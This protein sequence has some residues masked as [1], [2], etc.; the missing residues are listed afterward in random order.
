MFC[1]N[2]STKVDNNLLNKQLCRCCLATNIELKPIFHSDGSISEAIFLFTGVKIEESDNFPKTICTTCIDCLHKC[3]SFKQNVESSDDWL[4]N[5]VAKFKFCVNPDFQ[6]PY[7]I[8]ED[9]NYTTLREKHDQSSSCSSKSLC[10]KNST[11][12]KD[13]LKSVLTCS[14]CEA[15]FSF[16]EDFFIHT[17]LHD[18]SNGFI[19]K[20]CNKSFSTFFKLKRHIPTH[21]KEKPFKCQ[22]CDMRFIEMA[23]LT[24]HFRVHTGEKQQSMYFCEV[25]SKGFPNLYTLKVHNRIHTGERP[26]KCDDC[27]KRFSDYRLLNSHK[28]LHDDNKPYQC[29]DCN[30]NFRHR[31]TLVTHM[32]IH[33][34]N[35]GNRPHR[36][37]K[38]KKAFKQSWRLQIHKRYKH[39]P[40]NPKKRRFFCDQCCQIFNAST[41]LEDHLQWH[42]KNVE[43]N[44]EH[45]E[46]KETP[47]E[48]FFQCN[49]CSL[50]FSSRLDLITHQKLKHIHS[51]ECF[52]CFG[53]WKTFE[54]LIRHKCAEVLK[55]LE[56]PQADE[57]I[58]LPDGQIQDCN[59]IVNA[60][61]ASV[62]QRSGTTPAAENEKDTTKNSS[63]G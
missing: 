33:T 43:T 14:I 4:K 60:L 53:K 36:C 39:N 9:H 47:S 51:H 42:S 10:L 35:I 40:D 32:K 61:L 37:D 20:S 7:D 41:A 58:L 3:I 56:E 22:L 34:K 38:C 18:V 16:K 49:E 25:C 13:H 21:F 5:Q 59:T 62:T 8:S 63:M 57:M 1:K 26:W 55:D 17:S 6:K 46:P 11:I 12:W 44:K 19:C 29:K 54:E 24:R 15:S 27:D 23:S 52:N 45:Q 30:K 31:S 48:E 28:K 2:N 50:Q